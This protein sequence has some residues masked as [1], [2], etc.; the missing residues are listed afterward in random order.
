MEP[1][2]GEGRAMTDFLHARLQA[3]HWTAMAVFLFVVAVPVCL[4]QSALNEKPANDTTQPSDNSG[5]SGATD[6][7]SSSAESGMPAEQLIQVLRDNPEVMVEIKS[8]IADE[9]GRKRESLSNPMR[10]P[11]SRSTHNW[12]PAPRSAPA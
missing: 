2:C 12:R 5:S 6:S 1:H 9:V 8:V 3:S 10:S 4:S 11:I 7:D